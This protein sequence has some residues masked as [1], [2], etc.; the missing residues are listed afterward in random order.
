MGLFEALGKAQKIAT[1]LAEFHRLRLNLHGLQG[2][3]FLVAEPSRC[4]KRK[5]QMAL[6]GLA[7]ILHSPA[8]G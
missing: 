1:S 8:C 5:E 6:T 4:A 7:H 3:S 2:N